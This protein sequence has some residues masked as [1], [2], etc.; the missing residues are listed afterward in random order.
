MKGMLTVILSIALAAACWGIYGPVLQRGQAGMGTQ[1]D[2]KTIQSRLRP[3]I[4]V[5]M[6]YF[7][8]A[9]MVPVVMLAARGEKGNWSVGGTMW[10]LAAG[11]AGAI[12]ALGVILAFT[13][14]G[15]PI[16]VMPLIFGGAPIVNTFLTMFLGRTYKEAG[17]VFFAGLILVVAGAVAVLV[18]N[19]AHGGEGSALGFYEMVMVGVSVATTALAWGVYGPVLHK[20][21]LSMSGS[22]LRP[23]I[24][25]GIAYF[26]IAV[27]VP[28]AMLAARGEPGGWTI[29]GMTWSLAGGAAGALGALGIILAFNFGG[30]PVFVMP[31]VFGLA[32]VVST[33]AMLASKGVSHEISPIFYAGLI[34]VAVGAATVLIFAP[35]AAPHGKPHASSANGRPPA[36]Q[37]VKAPA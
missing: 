17:P 1:I 37:P 14:K 33:F 5:G 11:A 7:V 29:P 27:L 28:A 34:M 18:K 20:G 12:G 16:Y 36:E 32:P 10:S 3:F 26:L 21:Q 4:C 9:V 30:R 2:G 22:R 13:Y 35:K 19:P 6:A 8:I 31:L 25:V 24:C 23:F 15:N